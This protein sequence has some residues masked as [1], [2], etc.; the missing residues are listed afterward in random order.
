MRSEACHSGDK[1]PLAEVLP[2][3]APWTFIKNE[4]TIASLELLG[5]P[6]A[7]SFGKAGCQGK[8]GVRR[9]SPDQRITR[10]IPMR[11]PG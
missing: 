5:T 1:D 3:W 4:R 6:S 10:T 9:A 8:R 7:Q 11:S 2:C